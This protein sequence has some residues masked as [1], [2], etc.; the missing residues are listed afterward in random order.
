[1]I[2]IYDAYCRYYLCVFQSFYLFHLFHSTPRNNRDLKPILNT[3][4]K[5][6]FICVAAATLLRSLQTCSDP[7][8]VY[9]CGKV[10]TCKWGGGGHESA[11]LLQVARGR[12]GFRSPV[13]AGLPAAAVWA[14]V[15]SHKQHAHVLHA[16]AASLNV[17]LSRNG[18]K[19]AKTHVVEQLWD[20]R[21]TISLCISRSFTSRESTVC[22]RNVL[23]KKKFKPV[24]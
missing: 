1:M 21:K 18:E 23:K 8:N 19:S 11:S 6:S 13:C 4:G 22:D 20:W 17:R 9:P 3:F 14:A 16:N 7:Y 12:R 15:A 2:S 5:I 24:H 10:H